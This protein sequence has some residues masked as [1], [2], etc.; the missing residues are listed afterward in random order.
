[1][2]LASSRI[3]LT[4]N[5]APPP[6][7]R[8][9]DILVVK[10]SFLSFDNSPSPQLTSDDVGVV[11][12]LVCLRTGEKLTCTDFFRKRAN[13]SWLTSMHHSPHDVKKQWHWHLYCFVHMQ[14]CAY[15]L[16][17]IVQKKKKIIHSLFIV[18]ICSQFKVGAYFL[19]QCYFHQNKINITIWTSRL[20]DIQH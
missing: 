2:R 5:C 19:F 10:M 20:S 17:K 6:T 7:V 16:Y 8:D 1:M 15:D 14:E 9:V 12:E 4:V 18:P 11:F 13:C 3:F